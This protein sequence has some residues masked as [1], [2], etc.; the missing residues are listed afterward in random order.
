MDLLKIVD[1][2]LV[3]EYKPGRSWAYRGPSI[4]LL[5]TIIKKTTGQ[6]VADI[7]KEQGH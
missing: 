1:G 2:K 4:E 3:N 6:S 5:T 7:V